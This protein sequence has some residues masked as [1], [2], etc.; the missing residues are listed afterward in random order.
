[1]VVAVVTT[2]AL[3]AAEEEADDDDEDP[4]K[5]SVRP[6]RRSTVCVNPT[7]SVDRIAPKAD[8]C[9]DGWKGPCFTGENPSHRSRLPRS[10]RR[11]TTVIG[12]M[13]LQ[14]CH[15]TTATTGTEGVEGTKSFMVMLLVFVLL[16]LLLLLFV[17][18][19]IRCKELPV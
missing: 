18:S 17:M 1:M 2:D 13:V 12:V 3:V 19:R 4:V 7:D 14:R 5:T 15:E 6:C 10:R 9:R 8:E 11:T 16:L